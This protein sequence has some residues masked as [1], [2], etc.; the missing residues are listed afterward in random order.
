MSG[1]G[2]MVSAE[3][4]LDLEKTKTVVSRFK[5]FTLAESLGAVESLVQIPASMSNEK[6]PEEIRR[7]NGLADGL[8]RFSV[9]VEDIKDILDDFDQAIASV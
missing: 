1:F 3:F 6:I 4:A 9:G 5:V 8:V 2:G 7:K